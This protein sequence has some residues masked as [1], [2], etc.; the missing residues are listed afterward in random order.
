MQI[1]QLIEIVT[2]GKKVTE[3]TSKGAKMDFM[4]DLKSVIE[5]SAATDAELTRVK[6]AL[7]REDRSKASGHYKLQIENLSK[8]WG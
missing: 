2:E 5:K 8:K 1:N 6:L 4:Q 7:H 3:D